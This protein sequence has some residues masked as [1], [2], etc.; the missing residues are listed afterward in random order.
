MV[1]VLLVMLMML[2]VCVHLDESLSAWVVR[3]EEG[4]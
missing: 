1:A 2:F 4:A 3:G